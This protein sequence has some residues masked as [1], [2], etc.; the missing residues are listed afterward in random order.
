MELLSLRPPHNIHNPYDLMEAISPPSDAPNPANVAFHQMLS[1][2]PGEDIL[3]RRDAD[4]VAP[5]YN[6]PDRTS[7]RF[8]IAGSTSSFFREHSLNTNTGPYEEQG[9]ISDTTRGSNEG[10]CVRLTAQPPR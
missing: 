8:E 3:G 10:L 6:F 7:D 2:A 4:S 5:D 1:G 9:R